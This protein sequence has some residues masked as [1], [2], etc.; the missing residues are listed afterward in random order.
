[1][2]YHVH[3]VYGGSRDA[4]WNFE[5][6]QIVRDYV[7]PFING[8]VVLLGRAEGQTLVNMQAAD[9]MILYQTEE[10]LTVPEGMIAPQG[11]GSPEFARHACTRELLEEVRETTAP[12]PFRSLLQKAFLIPEDKAF[13]IMKLGDVELDS[14]YLGVIKPVV[15]SFGLG[16]VR[17]DEIQDSGN[18]T[19]EVLEAIATSRYII[20]DLSGSR[21]N[22]YYETGFSHAL[23]KE[24]ILTVRAAEEIH[25][26]LGG[27]RFIRWAT[28]LELRKRLHER[29]ESL[30]KFKKR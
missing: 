25:F 29:L 8:Q 27:Y 12:A 1:M 3:I 19:N 13:V 6:A 11:L 28:E 7:L 16:C 4:R 2:Y 21:P 24:I 23:G 9:S 22:C 26:D 15:I 17:I 30:R 14:A 18:I 5:K 10:P 20:S